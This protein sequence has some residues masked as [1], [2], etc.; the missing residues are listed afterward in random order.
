MFGVIYA[1]EKGGQKLHIVAQFN[2]DT[3]STE[4]LCGKKVSHWRMTSTFP[5][6]QCC[7]NCARV[8]RLNGQNRLKEIIK[9]VLKAEGYI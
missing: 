7:H 4:A 6:R 8:D 2:G 5:M 1:Q 9:K 3:V